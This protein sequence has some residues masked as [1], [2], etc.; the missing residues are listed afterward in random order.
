[1]P[2]LKIFSVA[3]LFLS[4]SG[5]AGDDALDALYKQPF[6]LNRSQCIPASV[7]RVQRKLLDYSDYHVIDEG[8]RKDERIFRIDMIRSRHQPQP[9][10]TPERRIDLVAVQMR[11]MNLN[12]PSYF[13]SFV[14]QCEMDSSAIAQGKKVVQT[15]LLRKD[16]GHYGIS[17]FES[18][19]EVTP[20]PDCSSPNSTRIT[21]DLQITSNSEDVRQ[22]RGAVLRVPGFN[23]KILD[24]IF[25]EERF[26]KTYYSDFYEEVI[27]QVSQPNPTD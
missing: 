1:M 7:D 11:P 20:D 4:L 5:F 26:F 3:F 23:N 2:T 25:N 24:K 21:Y 15:C 6:E 13:P 19:V 10:A 14:L 12:D 9:G 22:I 18:T 8:F 17:E 16:R 27:H